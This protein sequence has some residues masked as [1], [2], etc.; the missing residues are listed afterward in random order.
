VGES[1][2]FHV[3]IEIAQGSF[4]T[5]VSGLTTI[6]VQASISGTVLEA[7]VPDSISGQSYVFVTKTAMT[8]MIMDGDILAGPAVLEGEN[9]SSWT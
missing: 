6:S 7:A 2:K 1:I 3:D 5:F 8:G 4:L 9:H